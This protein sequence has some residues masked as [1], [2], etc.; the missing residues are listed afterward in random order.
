M[1]SLFERIKGVFSMR[2]ADADVRAVPAAPEYRHADM[3][4]DI[5]AHALKQKAAHRANEILAHIQNETESLHGALSPLI[6]AKHPVIKSVF[7][8]LQSLDISPYG[9]EDGG[10]YSQEKAVA[11]YLHQPKEV[12]RLFPVE[13][14]LGTFEEMTPYTAIHWREKHAFGEIVS[15]RFAGMYE[16]CEYE[17][18]EASDKYV[19]YKEDYPFFCTRKILDDGI[20]RDVAYECR[21]ALMHFD[22]SAEWQPDSPLALDEYGEIANSRI[23][24][25][26]NSKQGFDGAI[27]K[28]REYVDGVSI[29]PGRDTQMSPPGKSRGGRTE[30][31]HG[32]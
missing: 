29:V 9:P 15:S 19:Q 7:P 26:E 10:G 12:W 4:T 5:E 28:I 24:S 16:L 11:G 21:D 1:S 31:G 14:N 25:L 6:A 30:T 17:I 18:D 2:P 23:A 20:G 13:D 27:E 8:L 3:F 22:S 32:R